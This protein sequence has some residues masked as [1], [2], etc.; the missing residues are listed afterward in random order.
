[1]THKNT[2]PKNIEHTRLAILS[3]YYALLF[4]FAINALA[5]FGDFRLT[6]L[7]VWLIQAAPLLLFAPGLHRA[8][9]RTYGWV[10]FVILLYFMHGVVI[11]FE[12]ERLWFGLVEVLL[13]TLIFILL[14]IFIRLYRA[15]YKVPL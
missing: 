7:V 1:M 12:P 11:A 14:I 8:H 10:C 6:S 4:Y 5:V 15:H 13:C 9:L 2:L 3:S